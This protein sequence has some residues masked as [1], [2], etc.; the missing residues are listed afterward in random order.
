M[1]HDRCGCLIFQFVEYAWKVISQKQAEKTNKLPVPYVD[2]HKMTQ[3]VVVS[4]EKKKVSFKSRPEP[5]LEPHRLRANNTNAFIF[6]LVL[7]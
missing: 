5:N 6:H 2:V 7:V 3:A 1:C 4:K